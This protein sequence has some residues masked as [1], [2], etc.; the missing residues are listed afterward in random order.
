MVAINRDMVSIYIAGSSDV[1]GSALA[2]STYQIKGEITSWNVTGG[3]QDV[4]SVPAFGGFIDKEK[5]REQFEISMDVVPKIDSSAAVTDRW[6]ILKY[7]AE[8]KSS[9]EGSACTIAIVAQNGAVYKTTMIN[10]AK[11]T[12]WEPSHDADDNATGSITFKF[13]PED[14]VGVDN[15]RTSSLAPSNAYFNWA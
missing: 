7:G 14:D 2:T 3:T 4:E 10:N 9:G 12:M 13:S 15:L 8:G 1:N 5:P 6:D 11:V